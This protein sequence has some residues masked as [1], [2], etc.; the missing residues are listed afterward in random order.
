MLFTFSACTVVCWL[1]LQYLSIN[2]STTIIHNVAIYL[3]FV[4]FRIVE[5]YP[6]L[7]F[8]VF[9]SKFKLDLLHPI[10]VDGIKRPNCFSVLQTKTDG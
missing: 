4:C 1:A 9:L 3:A 8:V 6:I 7:S 2:P 5:I 10:R